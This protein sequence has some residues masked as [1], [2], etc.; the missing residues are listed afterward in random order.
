MKVRC[1]LVALHRF[2]AADEPDFVRAVISG[3]PKNEKWWISWSY[4]EDWLAFN[5]DD[6]PPRKAQTDLEGLPAGATGGP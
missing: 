5:P 1:E 6:Q 2:T 4:L 3:T